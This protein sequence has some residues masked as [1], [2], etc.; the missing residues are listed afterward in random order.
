MKIFGDRL[1]QLL[2]EN[3]LTQTE[4]ADILKTKPPTISKYCNGRIP[5]G[6]I[7]KE[8]ADY[9][10]VTTDYL[11]G[12]VDDPNNS[13]IYLPEDIEVEIKGN[14]KKINK[15]SLEN[16]ISKLEAVGFDIEKLL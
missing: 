2:T 3:N 9:F 15:E 14:T 11:Y 7:V 6:E 8:I 12:R 16:L 1:T 10:N 13:I 4:F 5:N